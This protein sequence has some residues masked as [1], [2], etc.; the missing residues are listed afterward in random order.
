LSLN[1][2]NQKLG[3]FFL[4]LSCQ[5]VVAQQSTTLVT[6]RQL[7][8][9]EQ[10]LDFITNMN[11]DNIDK[12]TYEALL[13]I[14]EE[15]KDA[16]AAF[17]WHYQYM[18]SAEHFKVFGK[19]NIRKI[20]DE[21]IKIA[22]ERGLE[23]ELIVAQ[24]Y[25]SIFISGD[26]K[27]G[28]QEMYSSFLNCFE[29]IKRLGIKNFQRYNL[30]A[31]LKI[32]GCN[33]YA[34]GDYEK[35][36]ECLLEAEKCI[37]SDSLVNV[38]NHTMTLN[39]IESI[40]ADT[41]N[42]PKAI[43]YAQKIIDLNLISTYSSNQAWY[44]I[45]WQGLASLNI[46][47]Y[48]FEIGNFK[49]GEKYANRGYELYKAQEDI[50]N[51][52]KVVA[53]FDALQVLVKIKLQLGKVDE[54][55]LL[56]KK[57]EFLKSRIDFSQEVN[58]FKPLRLYHNYYKYYEIQKEY[59]KAFRYLKLANEMQDSLN[60][61]NDKR[62]LWQIESRVKANNYIAQIKAAEEKSY[63]QES[64][65]NWAIIALVI[66]GVFGIV[67]YRII[68]KDHETIAK[69]KALLEQTLGE[70]ENLLKEIHHRVK[71]NLQLI[72]GLF[73]KQARQV[74]DETTK[75]LM[76]SGQDRIFSIALVH[77]NL[78][79][80]EH[81][82]TIDIKSYLEM[83]TEN[84]KKLQK[85]ELHDITIALDVDDSA[86][87]ID[88]AIPLGLILNELITNCYKYAFK[89]RSAGDILIQFSQHQKELVLIVQ[90][91]G[92]GLPSDF[93]LKKSRSL[94]MNLVLGLVRQIKGKLDYVSNDKGTTFKIYCVKNVE[95]PE[96]GNINPNSQKMPSLWK[97]MFA[98]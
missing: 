21:M 16:K 11:V 65:R 52:E 78:Y 91:N 49:E 37:K 3:L 46:A 85:S 51:M 13:P 95:D 59:N 69:Q 83:L 12:P 71:N 75:K 97:K 88:M 45:F 42:Y 43:A 23:A 41:K 27:L 4:F 96:Q 32:I 61:R 2:L 35:A 28:E 47:Q 55:A 15:K 72:S 6:F 14:I 44:P 26:K 54:V 34:L 70:K 79:Q 87:A 92:V 81:L 31:I 22:E 36:L 29:H 48:M 77:E 64:Q 25:L 10:R 58:Y 86:V 39:T 8:T 90:D 67:V 89:S 66:F 94:G 80:S 56:F 73:E 63:H 30:Q 33:F 84:I 18:Q 62:K 7:T 98:S 24:W 17:F 82:S 60:R 40:Y 74:T 93:D 38:H 5:W 68:K 9:T 57:I 20:I 76:K 1:S 50:K 53:A 19:E